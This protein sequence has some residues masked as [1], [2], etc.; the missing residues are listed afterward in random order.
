[1]SKQYIL[2]KKTITVNGIEYNTTIDRTFHIEFA[3]AN[4]KT[5]KSEEDNSDTELIPDNTDFLQKLTDVFPLSEYTI[6]IIQSRYRNH[7]ISVHFDITEINTGKNIYIADSAVLS[8]KD[9]NYIRSIMMDANPE[10]DWPTIEEQIRCHIKSYMTFQYS[11]D[12][13]TIFSKKAWNQLTETVADEWENIKIN[14]YVDFDPDNAEAI[15]KKIIEKAMY[16][17]L[18]SEN[19]TKEET[20]VKTTVRCKQDYIEDENVYWSEGCCYDAEK[21]SDGNWSIKTDYGNWGNVG[22]DYMLDE[23]DEY[24]EE[25]TATETTVLCI[26]EY[27]ENDIVYWVKGYTYKAKKLSDGNWSV[28][29]DYGNWEQFDPIDFKY[30]FE[31]VNK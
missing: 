19:Q 18:M 17:L 30:Y 1:M 23:F 22:P 6:K 29:N 9:Y 10:Y 3:E 13:E 7:A 16:S 2:A 4:Y 24:F 8:D 15:A 12:I 25:I 21:L 26:N 28:E 27:S 5:K 14:N 11:S 20:P 31:K